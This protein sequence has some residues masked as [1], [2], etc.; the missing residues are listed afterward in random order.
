MRQENNVLSASK[1]DGVSIKKLLQNGY[2]TKTNQHKGAFMNKT[3]ITY[4]S[5]KVYIGLDIHKKSYTLSAY[6]QGQ[7]VKTATTPA[8][9]KMSWEIYQRGFGIIRVFINM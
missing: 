8:N 9:P 1:K 3:A 4:K 6:C 2:V 7:V 5:K